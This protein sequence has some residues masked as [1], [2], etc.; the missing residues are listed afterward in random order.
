MEYVIRLVEAIGPEGWSAIV[1]CTWI[2]VHYR[3][4][5]LVRL[6][7]TNTENANQAT[8]CKENLH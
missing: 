4:E 6:E 1:I 7:R 2:I 3:H 8:D 5:H